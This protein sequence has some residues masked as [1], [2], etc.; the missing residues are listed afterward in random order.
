MPIHETVHAQSLLLGL[1]FMA[2]WSPNN[3]MAP[4]LTQV[5]NY[6]NMTD[7]ERDLYLGSF[8]ALA[9][10]VLSFPLSAAIGILTDLYPRKHLFVGTAIGGAIASAATGC[11]PTYRWLLLARF[12]SGGFM[13]A[14]V[15][16]SFSLLGDL[17]ATEER[18]AASSALTAMMGLGIIL[19]QVYAGTVG[20]SKGSNGTR[21]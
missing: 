11:S 2:I 12:F 4:N 6:Y 9:T 10:G 13:S 16:V 18:N 8:L 14:S 1:C 15:S 7:N 19:G 5:A 3:I 20:N 21:V 17:F